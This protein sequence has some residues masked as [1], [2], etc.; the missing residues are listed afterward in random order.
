MSEALRFNS[1]K[2]MMSYF[3]R[4]FPKMAEAVARVKEMGAIKYNDGNWRL[5]NKP[6]NEYWDSMFRHLTYIFS[7]EDYDKDTGCLHIAHAVWNLCALLELNYPDMPARDDEIWAE[8]AK[9]WADEKSKREA[10]DEVPGAAPEDVEDD[11][12][13]FDADIVKWVEPEYVGDVLDMLYGSGVVRDA[14]KAAATREAMKPSTVNAP[15]RPV[16]TKFIEKLATRDKEIREQYAAYCAEEKK[17]WEA[18]EDLASPPIDACP[19]CG[20]YNIMQDGDRGKVC[21]Y[22]GEVFDV[23]IV[24]ENTP[25]YKKIEFVIKDAKRP[26][27]FDDFLARWY[28][29]SRTLREEE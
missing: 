14:S 18:A 26:R 11:N 15:F 23:P 5:G 7:G 24:P 25:L 29:L 9:H 2:P 8:R 22:C 28:P 21:G 4:S 12:K 1:D 20:Y 3:M 6:D 13:I 10:T 19:M 17:K 27:S 16:F